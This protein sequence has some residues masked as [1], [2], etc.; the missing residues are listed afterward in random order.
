MDKV[1]QLDRGPLERFIT[2]ERV[3]ME[4][5]LHPSTSGSF[6]SGVEEELRKMVLTYR[7]TCAR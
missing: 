6:S 4:F 3:A 2:H 1:S 5:D 7:E